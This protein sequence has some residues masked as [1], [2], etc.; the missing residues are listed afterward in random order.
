MENC[1]P[2]GA[3]KIV[4]LTYFELTNPSL[5]PKVDEAEKEDFAKQI[6]WL[7]LDR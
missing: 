7:L 3:Y 4:R 1:S 6:L 5:G 2:K